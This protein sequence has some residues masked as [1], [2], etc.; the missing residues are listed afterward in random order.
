MISFFPAYTRTSISAFL[1]FYYANTIAISLWLNDFD[2]M[3]YDLIYFF[4]PQASE[5]I[6]TRLTVAIY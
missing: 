1:V 5:L 4:G 2:L 6:C 3:L